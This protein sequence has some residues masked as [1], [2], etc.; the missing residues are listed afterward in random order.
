MRK[1]KRFVS[2]CSNAALPR[3]E[4]RD[5]NYLVGSNFIV[6]VVMPAYNEEKYIAEAIKSVL[7][8]TYQNFELI[9]VNDGSKDKTMEIAKSFTDERINVIDLK[10]NRGV[11]YAC[12]V[13][14]D[15]AKGDWIAF[16]D[17]DDA[18]KP[19]RIEYLLGI[20]TRYEYG[21]YFI[22]DDFTLSYET[23][24]GKFVQLGS[25]L[26]IWLPGI[27]NKFGLSDFIEIDYKDFFYIAFQPILPSKVVKENRLRFP[28]NLNFA[29]DLYF[30]AKL[31]KRGLK[32]LITKKS[33]YFYRIAPKSLT[34]LELS[35]LVNKIEKFERTLE[36]DSEFN[37]ED[38]ELFKKY[39]EVSVRNTEKSNI[40]NSLLRGGFK[41][42]IFAFLKH[43]YPFL[44]YLFVNLSNPYKI[45]LLFK[46]WY[47]STA[48]RWY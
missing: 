8:Q 38:K 44:K 41:N 14:L 43:P 36:N 15:I 17:A 6:S 32:M 48:G 30:Y 39:F 27:Y 33:F 19:E 3:L 16:I 20:I 12:N 1:D 37:V 34:D 26:R 40:K 9:I 47:S 18:W 2:C 11:S 46:I 29:E 13:A 10:E 45:F 21:K 23:N 42:L 28:E 24:N 25:E 22:A 5:S 4:E 31:F 7:N 35:E